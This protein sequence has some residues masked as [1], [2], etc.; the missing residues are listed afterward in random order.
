MER[1]RHDEQIS[2]PGSLEHTK[3]GF[4]LPFPGFD[5]ELSVSGD[6]WTMKEN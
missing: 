2:L 4:A 1:E 6:E 3:K 5:F